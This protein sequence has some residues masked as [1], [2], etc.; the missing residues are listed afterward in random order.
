MLLP[1][2][3]WHTCLVTSLLTWPS[4]QVQLFFL[5]LIPFLLLL[6]ALQR[7]ALAACGGRRIEVCSAFL[8]IYK[9]SVCIK[10]FTAFLFWFLYSLCTVLQMFKSLKTRG[11]VLFWCIQMQHL[12]SSA[13]FTHTRTQTAR[14]IATDFYSFWRAHFHSPKR[15]LIHW[16]CLH[17]YQHQTCKEKSK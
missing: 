16:F 10:F 5:R 9:P 2:V 4:I 7:R 3:S 1:A 13:K 17:L 8:G 15:S 11:W 14:F 12:S 6:K